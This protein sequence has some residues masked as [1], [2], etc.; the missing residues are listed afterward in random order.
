MADR[1]AKSEPTLSFEFFPP[2]DEDGAA[3]LW[4]SYDKLLEVAPDFVSVTYGAGGSNRET[5]LAVVDRMAKDVLTVGHL[6]CVGAS[7]DSTREVISRFEAAGVRSILALR[8]D[9]PRDN[10]NA[11]AEGELKTALQLVELVA[12]ETSLE[13]GVAAFPE[14]HPESP[15]FAHDAKVLNLKQ[16]AGASYAITQ[17]F[18]TVDAYVDLVE[19]SKAAGATLPIVPGL[20]PIGNAE[21]IVR[22][23]QMSG[24]KLPVELL[25]KFESADEAQARVIGMDYSIK[26]ATDLIAAGAPGLHIYTLN[27]AK[28][29]IEVARGAGLCH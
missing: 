27:L 14:K 20:M 8:G 12:N 4:R 25:K 24:A 16:Q 7:R 9:S 23:A 21:R 22:M 3:S 19:T 6:T 15:D 11:L 2:K 28:A 29:A 18:F 1:A 26:L 17:L 10:P 5:S 13:V